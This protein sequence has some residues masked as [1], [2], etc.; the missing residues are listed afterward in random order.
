VTFSFIPFI[1]LGIEM[2]VNAWRARALM[3]VA[4][5]TKSQALEADAL[6]FT[7]DFFGS[8]PVI[9]GLVLSAYG[10]A[11]GDPLAA[12]AVWLGTALL[13]RGATL[14]RERRR[15]RRKGRKDTN[16]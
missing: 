14:L 13:L 15:R 2:T 16:Q 3:R 4:R 9:I 12:I 8:I 6:H 7:S 10:Y 5:E 1:V 11:W